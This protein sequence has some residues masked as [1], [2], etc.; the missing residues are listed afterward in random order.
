MDASGRDLVEAF[1]CTKEIIYSDERTV[2]QPQVLATFEK[3]CIQHNREI[4]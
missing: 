1:L 2:F 3:N 4:N